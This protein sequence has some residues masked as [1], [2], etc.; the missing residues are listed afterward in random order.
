MDQATFTQLYMDL[1]P[2]L[3]RLALSILHNETDAEDAVQ[4]A[5]VNTWRARERLRHGSE[6]AYLT[7]V[8][9]NVCRDI[10]RH[11]MRIVLTNDF[12]YAL[13]NPSDG[14]LRS[15]LD[16]LPEKLRTPLLLMYMEGWHE[17]EIASA[18]HITPYAVKS[19]LRRARA[20]LAQLMK[21][22]EG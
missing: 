14:T 16:R 10:Q 9:I 22:E 18:L 12:E 8:L 15:A 13:E 11:R 5:A 4:Q 6:R 19:R 7:R 20:A 17:L 21:E 2:G 1:L 3:Y